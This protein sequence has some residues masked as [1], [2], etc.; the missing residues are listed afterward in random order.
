MARLEQVNR[1]EVIEVMG[2]SNYLEHSDQLEG[3]WLLLGMRWTS[4]GHFKQRKNMVQLTC[5]KAALVVVGR[6]D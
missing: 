6:K 2:M 5:S 4:L 3:H 1:H